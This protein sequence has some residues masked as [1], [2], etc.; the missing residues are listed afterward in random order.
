L[1]PKAKP[2]NNN[3][4]EENTTSDMYSINKIFSNANSIIGINVRSNLLLK[5]LKNLG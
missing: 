3:N 2:P 1:V 5:Y 4:I